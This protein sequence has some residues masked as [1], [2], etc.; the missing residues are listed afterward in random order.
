MR[1]GNF[2]GRYNLLWYLLQ[3]SPIAL[4]SNIAAGSAIAQSLDSLPVPQPNSP[5]PQEPPALSSPTQQPTQQSAPIFPAAQPDAIAEN[6][7]VEWSGVADSQGSSPNTVQ[8]NSLRVQT[9]DIAQAVNPDIPTIP[10]SPQNDIQPP[11][12]LSLSPIQ[13]P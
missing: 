1:L 8:A 12:H 13:L 5:I 3:L 11:P 4:T 9:I 2:H 10:D 6:M 7:P